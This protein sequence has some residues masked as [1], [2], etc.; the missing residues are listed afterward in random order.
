MDGSKVGRDLLCLDPLDSTSHRL[1]IDGIR[2][3]VDLGFALDG[4]FLVRDFVIFEITP[5]KGIYARAQ[6]GRLL[7]VGTGTRRN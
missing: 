2:R 3:P 1:L 5:Q 7:Q 4:S 6:S